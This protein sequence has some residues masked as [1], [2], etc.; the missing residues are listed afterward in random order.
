MRRNRLPGSS[1]TPRTLPCPTT[2]HR[3]CNGNGA[4]WTVD[5]QPFHNRNKVRV[6]DYS[7]VSQVAARA[8]WETLLG[9]YGLRDSCCNQR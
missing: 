7:G 4:L 2:C 5:E 6:A 3:I 8:P 1:F 9:S